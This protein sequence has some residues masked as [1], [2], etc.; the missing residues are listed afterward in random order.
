MTF[1]R[2]VAPPEMAPLV[3]R[4]WATCPTTGD[5][6]M[7]ACLPG[8]EDRPIGTFDE[9]L[10]VAFQNFKAARDYGDAESEAFKAAARDL[11]SVRWRGHAP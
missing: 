3:W 7:I 5:P 6:I 1:T 10:D 8:D 4:Q 9:A 11:F 2:P